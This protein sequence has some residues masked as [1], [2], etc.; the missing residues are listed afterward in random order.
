MSLCPGLTTVQHSVVA[1]RGEESR[2]AYFDN[3]NL[4]FTEG[5]KVLMDGVRPVASYR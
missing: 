4:S 2:K 3:K 5:Y 1:L